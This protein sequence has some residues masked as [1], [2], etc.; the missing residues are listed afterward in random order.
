[1]N[2]NED[3]SLKLSITA[4]K[5]FCLA[6]IAVA[7]FARQIFGYLAMVD[8]LSY[9]LDKFVWAIYAL[10]IP[11]AV[12]L[13]GLYSLLMNIQAGKVFEEENVRLLRLLS[14][15]CLLAAAI[16]FGLGFLYVV[17]FVIAAAAGFVALILRVVKNVFAQAVAIKQDN[18]YTI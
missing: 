9:N 18:D 13:W 12:A 15:R 6:M 4:V 5:L 7:V 1:M 11:A 2:W 17:F 16:C 8:Y 14:W 3:K 10:C